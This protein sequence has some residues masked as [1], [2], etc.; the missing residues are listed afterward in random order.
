MTEVKFRLSQPVTLRTRR[1]ARGA[2][3]TPEGYL[4]ILA[5]PYAALAAIARSEHD[6]RG[7]IAMT[8]IHLALKQGYGRKFAF[9]MLRRS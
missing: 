5:V 1:L 8:W 2:R 7:K 9:G 3:P 4:V 6:W